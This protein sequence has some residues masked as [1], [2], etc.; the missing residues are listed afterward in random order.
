MEYL[1]WISKAIPKRRVLDVPL[2]EWIGMVGMDFG[3]DLEWMLEWISCI[4]LKTQFS[5]GMFA[6]NQLPESFT[7][8]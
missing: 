1:E 7:Y 6:R 3:M 2:V 5:P 8:I 4:S